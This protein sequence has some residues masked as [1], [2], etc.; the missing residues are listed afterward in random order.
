[1]TTLSQLAG[2]RELLVN[3]TLRD[4]R[5]RYRRSALGWAWSLANPLVTMLIFSVVFRVFLRV[6]VERGVYS[7]LQNFPLFLIIGLI[8]WSFFS[9]GVTGSMSSLLVNANLIKKVYFPRQVIVLSAVASAGVTLLIEAAVVSIVL[10]IVGN[11]VLPWLPIVL[12]FIIVQAA[13]VTGVALMLSVLNVYFRDLEY[14]TT[15]LLQMLFYATPVVYPLSLV[16]ERATLWG[17]AVPVRTLYTMNPMVRFVEIFRDCLY[18]LRM[19]GAKETLY[20]VAISAGT[21]LVGSL[22]FSRLQ[23]RLAEEL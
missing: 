4:L 11:F 16:P 19:P 5:G 14:L 8:F 1:M 10:M 17:M 7:G 21:L 15:L 22:V 23:R 18:H 6:P 20:V 13:F 3:L 12:F 2:A 9:V